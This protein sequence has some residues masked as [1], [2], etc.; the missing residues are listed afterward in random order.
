MKNQNL[1]LFSALP[2]FI[3]L[4]FSGNALK[5]QSEFGIKGGVNYFGLNDKISSTVFDFQKRSG[6]TFGVYYK[7]HDLAGPLG[8]QVELLY[9][10]KGGHYFIQHF[11]TSESEEGAYT[12]YYGYDNPYTGYWSRR[13][14]RYHYV[15]LPVLL[16]VSPLK[17]LDI[18]AGGE[19]GY[20][21]ARSGSPY[22]GWTTNRFTTGI[23]AGTALKIDPHTKLDIRYSRD[24]TRVADFGDS[25]I[26]NYGW[27]FTVQRS[28][29]SKQKQ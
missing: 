24:V 14:Q 25:D 29:F 12:G 19:M 6:A 26:K 5:A 10:Q 23:A 21:F 7:K 16:T 3:L 20:L 4:N 17:F 15:T 27:A 13:S 11:D 1:S 9:Q 2:L 18:Y 22:T 8:L 28:L